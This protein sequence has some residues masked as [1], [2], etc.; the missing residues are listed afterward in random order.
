MTNIV[1][2][3]QLGRRMVEHGRIRLGVKGQTQTG[4]VKP[5]SIDTFRFTSPD[6]SAIEQLA[7]LYG[8]TPRRWTDPK[9]SPTDQFEVISSATEIPVWIMPDQLSQAYELWSG[10]GCV[11]RCDGE[12]CE[13]SQQ[14]WDADYE[15]VLVPCIC[16]AK[17]RLECG[18]KTRLAVVI[19]TIRF[20]GAWR[21]ETKG[22][23][24]AEEMPAMAEM[25]EMLQESGPVNGF[26]A[27]ERRQSQ[28]GRRNFVVPTL[29]VDVTAQQLVAGAGG[30]TGELGTGSPAGAPASPA[31]LGQGGSA[32]PLAPPP[33]DPWDVDAEV[34]DA[35]I[36]E[37]APDLDAVYRL[38]NAPRD[39]VELEPRQIEALLNGKA[40]W[41]AATEGRVVRA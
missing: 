19:P 13:T 36:V 39:P 6:Q 38:P 1:P 14:T 9:A 7:A 40:K 31:A 4:K 30:V 11:R 25:I 23:N 32:A 18:L 8:G 37:E 34:V 20:G 16:G 21:V 26:L 22:R 2:I 3:Q 15:P 27:L 24:A 17:G 12:Q 35:E 41:S 29:R 33:R 28:G 10:G 5:Q